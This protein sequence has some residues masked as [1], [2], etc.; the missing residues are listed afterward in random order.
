MLRKRARA[1][2]CTREWEMKYLCAPTIDTQTRMFGA[3]CLHA[4]KK[5][6]IQ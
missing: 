3:E 2:A 5:T 6:Y 1:E 4:R